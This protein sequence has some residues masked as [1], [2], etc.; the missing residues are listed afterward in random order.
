MKTSSRSLGAVSATFF[1]LLF[2]AHA[3]ASQ[4]ANTSDGKSRISRVTV[5]ADRAEIT[6]TLRVRCERG[7][8][9]A[10]FFPLPLAIDPRTLRGET[11]G[12]SLAIGTSS[13]ELPVD[14]NLDVRAAKAEVE[15]RELDAQLRVLADEEATAV[16]RERSVSGFVGYFRAG[17]GEWLRDVKPNV[18]DWAK[19]LD[20]TSKE[21]LAIAEARVA[22]ASKERK[23][24][25]E[26]ARVERRMAALEPS[27]I[28]AAREA[29]VAVDCK[30]DV[31]VVVLLHYVVG[32]ATWHPEYDLSFT[33]NGGARV[34]PGRAQLTVG[35]IVQQSTGEDWSD[36]ELTLST[37]KPKLGTEA[38]VPYPLYLSAYEIERKKV[39]VSAQERRESLSTGGAASNAVGAES[40]ELEDR[41][42]SFV[43]TIPSKTSVMSDGRPYW[44]PVDVRETNATSRFVAIPKL[45][46]YVFQVVK[47]DNPAS[48]PLL[49]GTVHTYRAGSYVGD[50]TLTYKGPS[51][52]LELSLGIDEEL[53]VDRTSLTDA[54]K[55]AG[56]LSGTQHLEQGWRIDVENRSKGA[57][58]VEV[59]ES[60]PVSKDERITVELL[61]DK[62]TAGYQL[63]RERGFV[64]WKLELP[65]GAKKSVALNHAVHLPKDWKVGG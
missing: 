32:G 38:P 18:G 35:A 50:S 39:M 9:E 23:L 48:Y 33:P 19:T 59:R 61:K 10:R 14:E 42:Q 22:R 43:L 52:P 56:F 24:Q 3:S 28:K 12:P 47:L 49:E 29:V 30:S 20:S 41:G 40:A 65:K 6:R 1:V 5:F 51:E 37:A 11:V 46:A 21:R 15:L 44:M 25:A 16:D 60:I 57:V 17:L 45:R 62:T 31:D 2:G 54:A 13:R 55:R 63:D 58:V 53:R 26:R 64:T 27:R 4:P 7:S 36:V 34:G 8:A